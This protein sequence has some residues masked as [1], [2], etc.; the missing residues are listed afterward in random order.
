MDM[1]EARENAQSLF[2]QANEGQD[3]PETAPQE[4]NT[5]PVPAEA[6]PV[7]EETPPAE[8]VQENTQEQLQQMAHQAQFNQ[9][10]Q[11]QQILAENEQLRKANEDL[12]KTITQQSEV[13]QKAVKQRIM[14]RLDFSDMAFDDENAMAEKQAEYA[15][16]M[17]KYVTEG[18][19]EQLAPYIDRAKAGIRNEEKEKVIAL[20]ADTSELH[21]IRS[22][23][24]QLDNIIANNPE[25]F[26]DDVPIDTQLIT[27]YAIA[28]GA[29]SINTPP[30][31]EPTTDELMA[32]YDK[33]PDF[34][35]RIEKL[36]LEQLK[37]SQ[38]VPQ[39]SASSGAVNAAL[40]IKEKPKTM[41]DA[42]A[43]VRALF[44]Q[45]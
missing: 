16:A 23:L 5:E 24:P 22:M 40:N 39:M 34:R 29:N 43:G 7:Q 8:P 30:P 25:L 19:M 32:Y 15:E 37:N 1:E 17:E 28:R 12:Q 31:S 6:P 13:A 10:A 20:L 21:D 45:N 26:S 14:P 4:Q 44:K 36:R 27:A 42:S 33:N 35:D 18:V 11:I 9:Q 3:T 2:E 41:N 38:Q